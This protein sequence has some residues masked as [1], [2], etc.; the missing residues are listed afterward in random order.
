[1]MESMAIDITEDRRVCGHEKGVYVNDYRVCTRT[2]EREESG[3]SNM[4]MVI[5]GE[6][7]EVGERESV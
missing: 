3:S 5:K 4:V 7:V 1:M 2:K 6:E